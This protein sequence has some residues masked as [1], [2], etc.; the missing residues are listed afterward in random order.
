MKAAS[1]PPL[2]WLNALDAA[3]FVAALDGIVEHAPWVPHRIVDQRPFRSAI[4]LHAALISAIRQAPAA[5]LLALLNGH[6]ELAGQEATFGTLTAASNSEQHRL[7]LLALNHEQHQHL[8]NLNAAY[9]RR[10]GF[11]YIVALRLHDG[12]ASVLSDLQLRLSCD[13]LTE[14]GAALDQVAEVIRGRLDRLAAPAAT[15][16]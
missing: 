5:E 7:G 16:P 3:A 8:R 9:R 13:T 6:P 14:M 11:P 12:L 1:S 15:P 2:E 10:F 4:A